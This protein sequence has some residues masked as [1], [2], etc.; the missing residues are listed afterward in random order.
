M[1]E[2]ITRQSCDG[3]EYTHQRFLL[4]KQTFH[5]QF[6]H[7]YNARLDFAYPRLK[8]KAEKV[9]VG[10]PVVRIVNL[11][12]DVE[13]VIVGAL[14]KNMETKPDFLKEYVTQMGETERIQLDEEAAAF[15][16]TE[17]DSLSFEDQSGRVALTGSI[18]VSSLCTGL[19]LAVKG[20]VS[21]KSFIVDSWI[22]PPLDDQPVRRFDSTGVD[23]PC[24]VAFLSGLGFGGSTAQ[25]E[26]QLDAVSS[27]IRGNMGCNEVVENI[28]KVVIAGGL[29]TPTAD[30]AICNKIKLEIVDHEVIGSAPLADSMSVFDGWLSQLAEAVPVDV[31]PC[32]TDPTNAFIP[33]QPIHPCLLPCSF[34]S[35]NTSLVPSPFSFTFKG[36]DALGTSG[37]NLSEL[38]T[39][40]ID[41][42]TTRLLTVIVDSGLLAPT[43]PD[44][45]QCYPFQGTDPLQF[46]TQPRLLF[47][48]SAPDFSTDLVVRETGQT[49]VVA[50]PK[51]TEKP[52][53]TLVDFNSD[54]LAT[55]FIPIDVA[56]Q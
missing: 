21:G 42:P 50:V 20:K 12:E 55:M 33:Y 11:V 51:F 8:A 48:G 18:D 1:A 41:Q 38:H 4:K 14:Y 29:V 56:Q 37:E 7:L 15:R 27:F 26:L 43:A 3:F 10:V 40:T 13:S 5:Q 53:I 47:A 31:M 54:D 24:Y 46:S 52:G 6:S 9:W 28:S 45:L 39:Y 36:V 44:T 16:A 32:G 30:T 34:D 49:R 25:Q 22:Y 19:V 2:P 17:N 23:R 35:V